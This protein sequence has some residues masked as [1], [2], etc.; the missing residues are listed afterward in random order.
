MGISPVN[1]VVG[2]PT[3]SAPGRAE[4]WPR[5]APATSS[6]TQ[7]TNTP[8]PAHSAMARLLTSGLKYRV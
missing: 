8:S 1:D 6:T 7:E 2:L 3:Q 4:T 5:R